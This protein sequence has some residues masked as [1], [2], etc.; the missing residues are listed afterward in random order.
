MADALKYLH[1]RN[2]V[3][4]SIQPKSIFVDDRFNVK[5]SDFG[6]N[7]LYP[8]NLNNKSTSYLYDFPEILIMNYTIEADIYA[9]GCIMI[10]MLSLQIPEVDHE[11]RICMANYKFDSGYERDI[12]LLAMK[13]MTLSPIGINDPNFTA[14]PTAD[15]L[16]QYPLI[17]SK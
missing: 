9:L 17:K 15:Q 3:H 1:S 13:C 10:A 5:L 2:L 11:G 16:L 14:P 12:V 6:L 8:G 7:H 4:K